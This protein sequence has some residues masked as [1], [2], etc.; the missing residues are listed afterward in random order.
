MFRIKAI[1]H[2]V[3]RSVNLDKM[4]SFYR[5][6]LGCEV[7][8]KRDD[9][10]LVHLMAGSSLIDFISVD[11][12]LGRAGGV[13]PA[14]EGRN[15]AHLCLSIEPFEIKELKA[16]FERLGV[17]VGELEQN[18]GAEGDGPSVYISDPEGNIIELK[19]QAAGSSRVSSAIDLA[20]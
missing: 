7:E 15:M 17:S 6:A 4:V 12:K 9:L 18:Y 16:Y 19:R 10:G 13:A 5:D 11:G 2:V 14:V 1:D 3:I 8:K 20:E